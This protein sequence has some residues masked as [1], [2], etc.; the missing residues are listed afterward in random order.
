MP[1]DPQNQVKEEAIS[2]VKPSRNQKK[3]KDDTEGCV[4][5]LVEVMELHK[6]QGILKEERQACTAIFSKAI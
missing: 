5:A 3:I 6:E 1:E 2:S 4:D